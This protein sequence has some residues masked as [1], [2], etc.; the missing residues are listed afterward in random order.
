[1]QPSSNPTIRADIKTTRFSIPDGAELLVGHN[2][3]GRPAT[4]YD[5]DGHQLALVDG[6]SSWQP[7]PPETFRP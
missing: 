7:Y 1:M 5:L 2:V 4:Y 3:Y 6:A